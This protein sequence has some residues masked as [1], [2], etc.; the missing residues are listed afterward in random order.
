MDERCK[1]QG[2]GAIESKL[3]MDELVRRLG[4]RALTGELELGNRLRTV[5][6]TVGVQ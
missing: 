6:S 2:G 5:A 3:I 1:V 4:V